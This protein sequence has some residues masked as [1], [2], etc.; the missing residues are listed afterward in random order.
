M[1]PREVPSLRITKVIFR[2]G[3]FYAER[4]YIMNKEI[5]V[6]VGGMDNE[7]SFSIV[8]PS[9][10]NRN[11]ARTVSEWTTNSGVMLPKSTGEI[12]SFFEK[13]HS[14]VIVDGRGNLVSHAAA[15]FIYQDGSIE[16]GAMYTAENQRGKGAST[17]AVLALLNL[18]KDKYPGRMIF[19]LANSNSAPLFE[20]LGATKMEST[21]LS[22]EVWEP[23]KTCP[24]NPLLKGVEHAA[25][26]C[27]DT[28]Y[29]L[30]NI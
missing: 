21:E 19:A 13:G 11:Y 26:S 15:T 7:H 2:D 30:T 16:L 8:I 23:C 10:I 5:K 20:R 18:L 27:C 1:V 17:K 28:P 29:N 3:I 6:G 24:K 25:F 4:V 22:D 9:A 14:V 12:I